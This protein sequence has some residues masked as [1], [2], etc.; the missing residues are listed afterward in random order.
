M[1]LDQIILCGITNFKFKRRIQVF[2]S[3]LWT[4]AAILKPRVFI[5]YNF[6]ELFNALTY[7]VTQGPLL[8]CQETIAPRF[9]QKRQHGVPSLYY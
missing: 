5:V 1:L 8:T 4:V 9:L 3:L 6:L 2:P 7:V